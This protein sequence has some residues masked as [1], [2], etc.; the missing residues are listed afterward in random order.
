M[1]PAYCLNTLPTSEPTHIRAN[2]LVNGSLPRWSANMFAREWVPPTWSQHLT[3]GSRDPANTR[4][5]LEPST[6]MFARRTVAIIQSILIQLLIDRTS[7]KT[8]FV[9]VLC[10]P[11]KNL[12]QWFF[13]HSE[14]ILEVL[15]F[16]D[17]FFDHSCPP[18]FSCFS[19]TVNGVTHTTIFTV[20]RPYLNR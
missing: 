13:N 14:V 6:N 9:H 18:R 19:L 12:L 10:N 3:S 1:G 5:Q 2:M 4:A 16:V 7:P 15:G 20:R 17:Q 8:Q 11:S